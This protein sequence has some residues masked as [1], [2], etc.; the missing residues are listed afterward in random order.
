MFREFCHGDGAGESD[1]EMDVVFNT[2]DEE[3]FA[4]E[5]ACDG[6]KIGVEFWADGRFE[7]GSALFGGKDD[8][9]EDEREGLWHERLLGRA[10][11]P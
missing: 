5:I 3:T 10:F 11:G 4:V 8:V 9:E 1:G 7:K 2:A 6:G